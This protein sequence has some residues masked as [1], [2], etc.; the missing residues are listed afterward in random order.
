MEIWLPILITSLCYLTPSLL[1]FKKQIPDKNLTNL[2]ALLIGIGLLAH[3]TILKT[4]ISFNP[5]NL[6]FSNAL[7]AT[8]FFSILIFWILNFNKN[9]N[10]LQPFLLIPSAFLLIIHPLFVSNHFLTTDLSPL[11]MTHIAIALLAYSLFTFSAYVAIFILIFEKKLHQKK[12]IDMILSGFQPL[13][14]MEK[15]THPV[16]VD[17]DDILSEYATS[18]GWPQISLR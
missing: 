12:K 17:S 18:K 5:I 15:V 16:A 4:S 14:E 1:L 3:F 6:G 7:I 9:F 11:F 8:S 2:N 13:I 10:Y